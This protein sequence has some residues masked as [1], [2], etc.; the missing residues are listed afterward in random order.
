[1]LYV[2]ADFCSHRIFSPIPPITLLTLAIQD[3]LGCLASYTTTA[4]ADGRT[5]WLAG[6]L[7]G[8]LHG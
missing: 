8:W 1:M 5:G 4:K 3:E 7:A 6:W 2:S